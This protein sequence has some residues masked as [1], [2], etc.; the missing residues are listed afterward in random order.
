MRELILELRDFREEVRNQLSQLEKWSAVHEAEHSTRQE[1]DTAEKAHNAARAK[2]L[3]SIG[4][5]L[6]TAANILLPLFLHHR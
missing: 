6:F 1:Q 2:L 5:L 4:G 3:I